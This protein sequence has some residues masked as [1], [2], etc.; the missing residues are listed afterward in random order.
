MKLTTV[1][2]S[3]KTDSVHLDWAFSVGETVLQSSVWAD[4]RIPQLRLD[5]HTLQNLPYKNAEQSALQGRFK[6]LDNKI[7]QF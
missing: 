3:Q 6:R 1:L 5:L 4:C 2:S 7:L